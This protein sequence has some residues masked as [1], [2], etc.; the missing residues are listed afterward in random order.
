MRVD[1]RTVR[2][3]DG[4]TI[5]LPTVMYDAFASTIEAAKVHAHPL[6]ARRGGV[7]GSLTDHAGARHDHRG[8]TLP[9]ALLTPTARP[10]GASGIHARRRA[11]SPPASSPETRR[12]LP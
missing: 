6:R 8:D 4:T 3:L 1:A 2:L 5:N 9:P 7:N 12:C 10:A 11:L